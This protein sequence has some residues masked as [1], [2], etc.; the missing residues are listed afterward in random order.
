MT[1]LNVGLLWLAVVLLAGCVPLNEPGGLIEP[2]EAGLKSQ[3]TME[4]GPIKISPERRAQLAAGS[5]GSPAAVEAG[6]EVPVEVVAVPEVV[7]EPEVAAETE[8]AAEPE[9]VAEPEVATEV[10]A[11]PDPPVPVVVVPPESSASAEPGPE[12]DPEPDPEP[13]SG[14]AAASSLSPPPSDADALA[15]IDRLPRRPAR[16]A[17]VHTFGADT[18]QPSERCVPADEPSTTPLTRLKM[19]RWDSLGGRPLAT[20]A[21]PSGEEFQVEIGDRVGPHG[22]L[23]VA[24]DTSK[25]IVYELRLDDREE[26]TK[27]RE[28]I[29]LKQ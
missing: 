6:A 18:S 16:P 10:A 21:T 17:P 24:I 9:V 2:L 26:P 8:V 14:E 5:A 12:P 25:V 28:V 27:V 11:E 13:P 23:V 7:A 15:A 1:K 3:S 19:I 22:G 29:K 20:L 4:T